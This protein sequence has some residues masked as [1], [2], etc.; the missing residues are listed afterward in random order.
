VWLLCIDTID[1]E[2]Y[3]KKAKDREG[4]EEHREYCGGGERRREWIQTARRLARLIRDKT[5]L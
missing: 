4:K 5:Y 2:I 1:K 3:G